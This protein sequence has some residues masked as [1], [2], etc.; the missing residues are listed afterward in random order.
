MKQII[1]FSTLAIISTRNLQLISNRNSQVVSCSRV[2][3]KTMKPSLCKRI[4]IP[5]FMLTARFVYYILRVIKAVDKKDFRNNR[6][7]VVSL[8]IS[9]DI[10]NIQILVL[11]STECNTLHTVNH[12]K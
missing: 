9:T 2:D 4:V 8:H 6:R 5:L 7:P 1:Q 11:I 12:G 10:I 3:M